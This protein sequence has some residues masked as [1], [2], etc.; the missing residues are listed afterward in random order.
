MRK[1]PVLR[2]G[3]FRAFRPVFSIWHTCHVVHHG[4]FTQKQLRLRVL[5]EIY[6]NLYTGS[7][8]GFIVITFT[9]FKPLI[10]PSIVLKIS[11]V[12]ITLYNLSERTTKN[13][14]ALTFDR[15]YFILFLFPAFPYFLGR[16]MVIETRIPCALYSL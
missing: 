1:T 12:F 11:I 9:A 15:G 5:N 7:R 4:H 2:C 13:S 3:H 10:T 8:L 6:T 16:C 14:S